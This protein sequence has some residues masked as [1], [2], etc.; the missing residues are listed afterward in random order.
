MS[1]K[2]HAW[3]WDNKRNINMNRILDNVM[4]LSLLSIRVVLWMVDVCRCV[5]TYTYTH[6]CICTERKLEKGEGRHIGKESNYCKLIII[7]E[8]NSRTHGYP[9]ISLPTFLYV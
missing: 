5:Y 4:E 3:D 9:L 7:V 8:S 1:Y 2:R 6:T